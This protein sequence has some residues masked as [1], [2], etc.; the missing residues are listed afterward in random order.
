LW[1]CSILQIRYSGGRAAAWGVKEGWDGAGAT[2]T[3]SLTSL[4]LS[5]TERKED[6][7]TKASLLRWYSLA[8][9]RQESQSFQR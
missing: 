3:G 8:W 4:G 2:N 1:H 7:E 9:V 5:S 6:A